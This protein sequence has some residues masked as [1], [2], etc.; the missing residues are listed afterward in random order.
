MYPIAKNKTLFTPEVFDEGYKKLWG[1]PYYKA[2]R[3]IL[4]VIAAILILSIAFIIK[5]GMPIFFLVSEVFFI[6]V[7]SAY[8][9]V[10]IPRKQKKKIF[11][12]I[13]MGESGTPWRSYSFYEDHVVVD[14]PNGEKEDYPYTDVTEI[15]HGKNVILLYTNGNHNILIDKNAFTGEIPD[16][17]KEK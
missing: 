13:G 10:V 17:L 9:L 16:F 4:Y 1:A 5:T 14:F 7:I 3:K 6:V 2:I 15:Y 11:K 12:K 8:I